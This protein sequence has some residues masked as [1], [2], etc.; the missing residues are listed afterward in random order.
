MEARLIDEARAEWLTESWEGSSTAACDCD[1]Q[2]ILKEET[3]KVNENSGRREELKFQ[4][5]F[6]TILIR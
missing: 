1:K 5:V 2:M 3:T 6:W 4:S